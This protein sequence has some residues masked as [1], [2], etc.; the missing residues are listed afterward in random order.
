MPVATQGAVETVG[1]TTFTVT[2]DF[3]RPANVTAY[4]QYDIVSA[5]ASGSTVAFLEFD[6]TRA[7]SSGYLT[8]FRLETNR[9]AEAG[10]Y[11]LWLYRVPAASL[12]T[13]PTNLGDNDLFPLIFANRSFRIGYVDFAAWVTGGSGSDSA[14]ALDMTTRM[15]YGLAA[16]DSKLYGLLTVNAAVTP[17]NAQQFSV[18]ISFE[19]NT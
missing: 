1:G 11:R 15:K 2:A 10:S 9:T 7:N 14:L 3:T 13:V 6:T 4:A 16:A 18:S 19:S 8:K 12:T 5:T 17:A